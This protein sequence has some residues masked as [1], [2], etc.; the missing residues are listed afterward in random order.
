[1]TA[2]ILTYHAIEEGPAPLCVAPRVFRAHLDAIAGSGAEVLTVSELVERMDELP[3]RAVAITFDDGFRSVVEEAAPLLDAR[4]MPATVFAVAGHLGADNGWP[5]QPPNALRRPLASGAELAAL[6][7][8]GWEIGSHGLDHAP[9]TGAA[10][11]LLQREL[12]T[13]RERLE[14]IVH[15]PVRSYAYPYGALPGPE[16][17]LAVEHEYAAACTTELGGVQNGA[18][19]HALPRLEVH[20]VRRPDLL[21]RALDGSLTTYLNARRLGARARRMIRRDYAKST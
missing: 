11:V 16:G 13:S 7:D 17:R 14:A 21:G 4:R 8:E 1:M 10:G 5:T 19:P 18:D 15:A 6:V 12:V 2:L 20:Y 9:L 3:E